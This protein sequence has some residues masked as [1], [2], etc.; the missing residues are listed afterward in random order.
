[1]SEETNN[2]AESTLAGSID[3]LA[4][5]ARQQSAE[6]YI[7]RGA[8]EAGLVY[9]LP[10][11]PEFGPGRQVVLGSGL[12]QAGTLV[13]IRFVAEQGECD[14]GEPGAEIV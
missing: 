7:I 6:V 2:P 13:V 8:T 12:R 5:L 11:D 4:T 9:R 14:S 10:G 1:M 3:E